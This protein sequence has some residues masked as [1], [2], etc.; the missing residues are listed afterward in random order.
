MLPGSVVP[1]LVTSEESGMTSRV[2]KFGIRVPA[3]VYE[4]VKADKLDNGLIDDKVFGVKKRGAR[5][6]EYRFEVAGGMI[7]RW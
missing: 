7:T 4:K 2:R 1:L 5:E 6:V 3:A